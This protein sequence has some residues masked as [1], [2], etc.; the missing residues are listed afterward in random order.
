[1]LGASIYGAGG[2]ILGGVFFTFRHALLIVSTALS[3]PDARLFEAA[4]AL[5]AS[6]LR[7]YF[8]VTLPGAG[9][10][11][12]SAAFVVFTLKI[13]DFGVPKVMGGDLSVLAVDLQK[14]VVGQQSFAMGAVVSAIQLVPAVAVFTVDRL[15]AAR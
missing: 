14:P 3:F 10:G 7:T 8:R 2:I 4:R 11:L 13:T 5:R 1:M 6:P 12:I 15:V 9:Y